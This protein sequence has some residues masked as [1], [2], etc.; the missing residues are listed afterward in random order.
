[1]NNATFKLLENSK[2]LLAYHS[3]SNER[4]TYKFVVFGQRVEFGPFWVS[5]V[6][7]EFLVSVSGRSLIPD[8]ILLNNSKTG[9]ESA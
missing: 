1:M 9:N 8:I 7:F 6:S 4:L 3:K 5:L 2:L